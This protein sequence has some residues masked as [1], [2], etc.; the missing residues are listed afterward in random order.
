MPFSSE[1]RILEE[2]KYHS[3]VHLSKYCPNDGF[4]THY[5]RKIVETFCE[6]DD[7]NISH[8]L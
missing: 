1:D 3:L 6:K 5:L 7:Q 8:S 2:D 4:E